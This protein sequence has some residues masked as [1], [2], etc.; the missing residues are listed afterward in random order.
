MVVEP[1]VDVYRVFEAETVVKTGEVVIGTA[2]PPLALLAREA[3]AEE[4]TL[5]APVLGA[6]PAPRDML[7]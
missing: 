2:P 5:G 6:T 4:A 7:A 1:T 3:E